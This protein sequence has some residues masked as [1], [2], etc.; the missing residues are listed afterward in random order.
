MW[1]GSVAEVAEESQPFVEGNRL[2]LKH[3]INV[4]PRKSQKTQVDTWYKLLGQ[5]IRNRNFV[6]VQFVWRS[7]CDRKAFKDPRYSPATNADAQNQRWLADICCLKLASFG[8][9]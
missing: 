4:E 1:L 6:F 8:K 5:M 9:V 2:V 7:S 3:T